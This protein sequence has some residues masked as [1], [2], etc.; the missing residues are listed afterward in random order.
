MAPTSAGV[1]IRKAF[2]A[3]YGREADVV[4]AAP[5]RVNLIGEHTDYNEGWV[6]PVAMDRTIRVAAAKRKDRQVRATSE[7]FPGLVEFSLDRIEPDSSLRWGNYVRGVA[8]SLEQAGFHLSGADL[9]I[10]GDVPREAGLSSSAALEV[11]LVNCWQ[12]L[13]RI[14]LAPLEVVRLARRAENDFVGVPCG[15]MDQFIAHLGQRDHALLLDCRDL[16]YRQIPLPKDVSVVVSN[17]GVKRS[18]AQSEYRMRVEQCQ[19]AL[20]QLA[21]AGRSASSLRDIEPADLERHRSSLDPL[22]WKRASHVVNENRR[23]LEA[24]RALEENRVED[25]GRLMNE[26]H[27]SLRDDYEVSCAELD[28]MAEIARRQPGVLGSRMTGAGFGGCTVTLVKREFT[29][30]AAAALE[31]EYRETTAL[32]PQTFLFQP[33]AGAASLTEVL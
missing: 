23:T 18:L 30:L 12:R 14:S 26:S 28:T 1:S 22:V 2:R 7:Q 6:L 17:T 4:R 32:E 25:F 9:W 24:V 27:Q 8:H 33:S 31:K 3:S 15:V 21:A 11:A 13:D 10:S 29:Q 20:K 16:S 19:K 5:G